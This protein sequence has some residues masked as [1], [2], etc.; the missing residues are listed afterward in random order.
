MILLEFPAN[1]IQLRSFWLVVSLIIGLL[2]G[3]FLNIIFSP[4]W[5]V[6]GLFIAIGLAIPGLIRPQLANIPY[7]VFNKAARVFTYCANEWI[8]FVC[9]FIIY[10]TG[11]TKGSSLRLTKPNKSES[12]WEPR[13]L[14]S[15][16][17]CGSSMN[18]S[19]LLP[20]SSQS[21][22]FFIFIRWVIKS[23]NWRLLYL[24]PYFV[25]IAV[26]RKEKLSTT[27]S[28]NVYTLY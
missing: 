28:E 6:F 17:I 25:L 1:I 21:G 2:I 26:F 11:G 10:I 4:I 18:K 5:F 24:L 7:R 9:F 14:G 23:G 3:F 19:V 15:P 20:E 13:S 8:L 16:G 12:L 22:W 27:I